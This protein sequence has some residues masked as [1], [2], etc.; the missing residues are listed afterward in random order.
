[1]SITLTCGICG[2][3][4]LGALLATSSLQDLLALPAGTVLFVYTALDSM[5]DSYRGQL[6]YSEA[7]VRIDANIAPQSDFKLPGYS[8]VLPM[9]ATS[10]Y[11]GRDTTP[12]PPVHFPAYPNVSSGGHKDKCVSP[13]L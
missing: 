8:L 2:E 5:K 1:M 12:A 4:E 6:K 13:C 3:W 10:V 9:T 7:Q 11:V